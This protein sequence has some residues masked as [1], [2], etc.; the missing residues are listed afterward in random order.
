ML[1]LPFSGII[2]SG[3]MAGV[4]LLLFICERLFPLRNA[5][6]QLG[7]RLITNFVLTLLVFVV[8]AL[9]V[10]PV[11]IYLSHWT[12][13]RPF[14]LLHI[15][16]MPL[17][18]QFTLGFLLLDLTFYYWHRANHRIELLWRF[19][20][21]HH[22]DPDLDVSTSFRFHFGEVLLSVFF[23]IL[24]VGLLGVSFTT[25]V[26][27]EMFFQA[28]TMFHHSNVRLPLGLERLLNK[29]V[30]TPRMHGIH[31][32]VVHEEMDSNYSVIFRWW[33]ALNGTLRLGVRQADLQIG[34][35]AYKR[36][37]DN[38]LPKVLWHPFQ[39]QRRYWTW[40]DGRLANRD[41]FSDT[42]SMQP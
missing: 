32:S 23:R 24:Q 16:E 26:V 21:V 6:F 13:E 37:I 35:A 36:P 38:S 9:T 22:L 33:D 18:L 34:V 27:Y 2:Y 17:W 31:H 3:G 15:V 39:E 28:A 19:H 11:G 25:Y 29:I 12:S 14:G 41:T 1:E 30:V 42:C 40:P 8:S 20:N 5:S 7:R 10:K 4:F